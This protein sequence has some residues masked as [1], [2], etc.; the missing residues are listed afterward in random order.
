MPNKFYSPDST[1]ADKVHD[2]FAKIARRYD[3]L[4]DLMSL[5][6][7]RIW[8]RQLVTHALL[9]KTN[10]PLE[11]LDICCGTGDLSLGFQ[12]RTSTGN[13]FGLDFTTEML[14]VAQTRSSSIPWVQSDALQLP[15]KSESFDIVSVGYGLR[16]LASIEQGLHEIHRVL[17]N[18]GVFLSLDFGKPESA[19]IRKLYFAYLKLVLPILGRIFF[20]DRDTHGYIL[21]SLNSYPAQ[22]GVKQ[23]MESC[24]FRECDFQEFYGGTM[25]IN[26]GKKLS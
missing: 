17:K 2:L 16:N 20:R 24:G 19:I 26:F 8:K 11:I 10:Q 15:F 21:A 23:Q 4:N 9:G 12:R 18:N 1:R 25:A 7:H 3:F 13:I 5:G 22:R 6:L 14:R